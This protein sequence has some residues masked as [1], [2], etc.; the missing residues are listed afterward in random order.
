[1]YDLKLTR[2]SL[3]DGDIVYL[4]GASL[5]IFNSNN[6]FI[7]QNIIKKTND[8]NKW[9]LLMNKTSGE[10]KKEICEYIADDDISVSFSKL[11]EKRNRIIHSFGGTANNGRQVLFTV[12]K[13]TNRQFEITEEYLKEFIHKNEELSDKLYKYR[14]ALDKE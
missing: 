2:M 3:P 6:S 10:I 11:V 14:N 1:M 12:D 13:K 9:Y 4:I 5:C 7:I 8:I